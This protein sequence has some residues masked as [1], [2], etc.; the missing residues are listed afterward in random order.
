MWNC[1]IFTLRVP[2][3]LLTIGTQTDPAVLRTLDLDRKQ[4]E[5][6]VT[7]RLGSV[8]VPTEHAHTEV[9]G[10]QTVVVEELRGLAAEVGER[11]QQGG[12]GGLLGDDSLGSTEDIAS[13]S[14]HECG[15]AGFLDPLTGFG[16]LVRKRGEVPTAVEAFDELLGRRI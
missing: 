3:L 1:S 9:E 8:L 6:G 10:P 14:H 16:F 12:S 7:A 2:W 13:P 11:A 15:A 4:H 5:R